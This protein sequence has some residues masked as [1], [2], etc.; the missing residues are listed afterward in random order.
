MIEPYTTAKCATCGKEIQE[1][2][3]AWRITPHLSVVWFP[4]LPMA[5]LEDDQLACSNSCALVLIAKRLE[6]LNPGGD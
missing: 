3:G 5:I 4:K 1:G 6:E 2:Q